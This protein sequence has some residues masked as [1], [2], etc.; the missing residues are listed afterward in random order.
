MDE[1]E[2]G[3]GKVIGNRHVIRWIKMTVIVMMT[4]MIDQYGPLT[5]YVKLR[6][7]HAPGNAGNVFPT[8]DFKGNH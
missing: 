4:A 2:E 8:T 7:A 1:E 3:W 5:K 6:V